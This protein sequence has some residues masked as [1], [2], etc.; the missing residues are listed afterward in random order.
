VYGQ[1]AGAIYGVGA[2]PQE[3]RAKLALRETI[4]GLAD[5]LLALAETGRS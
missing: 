3:W 5:G 2:I 4:E 1:L